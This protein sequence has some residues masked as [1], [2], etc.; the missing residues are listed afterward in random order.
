MNWKE[1]DVYCMQADE[2]RKP[3]QVSQFYIQD[4]LHGYIV[5]NYNKTEW[6]AARKEQRKINEANNRAIVLYTEDG[7]ISFSKSDL[8]SGNVERIFSALKSD[9]VY[10]LINRFTDGLQQL[11]VSE[12][13]GKTWKFICEYNHIQFYS[14]QF[15]NDLCGF[16]SFEEKNKK[17]ILTTSDGGINWNSYLLTEEQEQLIV[18]GVFLSE[19]VIISPIDQSKKAILFHT[20]TQEIQIK[21]LPGTPKETVQYGGMVKDDSTG[22]YYVE[23]YDQKMMEMEY[24]AMCATKKLLHITRQEIFTL[25]FPG[26]TGYYTLSN[27]YIGTFIEEGTKT[28]YYYSKDSG[29]TWQKELLPRPIVFN[30][31]KALYQKYAWHEDGGYFV[32]QVRF[33]SEE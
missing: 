33:P 29:I 2:L 15:Y 6:E 22:E 26:E 5:G 17:Y 13:Y 8:G 18:N 10:I 23:L 16:I 7:G 3:Y 1:K 24:P 19:N 11:M 9:N 32:L 12:N 30:G 28:Y 25:P 20:D 14:C 27:G 4:S 21:T 31:E